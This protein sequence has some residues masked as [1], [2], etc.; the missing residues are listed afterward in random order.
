M[1][2]DLI[3]KLEHAAETHPDPEVRAACR[4]DADGYRAA[5]AAKSPPACS[6]CGRPLVDTLDVRACRCS[7]GPAGPIDLTDEDDD[8]GPMPS[9]LRPDRDARRTAMNGRQRD[10][11]AARWG[12]RTAVGVT[13]SA[14]ALLTFTGHEPTDN[15]RANATPVNTSTDGRVH[16]CGLVTEDGVTDHLADYAQRCGCNR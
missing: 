4:R 6:K 16:T 7:S 8:H 2:A 11:H 1:I 14:L 3:A 15:G 12:R 9:Q 13:L 10:E 5:L